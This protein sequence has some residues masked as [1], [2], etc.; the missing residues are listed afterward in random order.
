MDRNK[1]NISLVIIN[2]LGN[3]DNDNIDVLLRII[4]LCILE[5]ILQCIR[6]YYLRASSLVE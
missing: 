2:M 6:S 5:N 4:T 1:L 3:I